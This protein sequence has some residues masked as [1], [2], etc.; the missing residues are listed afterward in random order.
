MVTASPRATAGPEASSE[1]TGWGRGV[2]AIGYGL[3]FLLVVY[4]A[5]AGGGYDPVVYGEVGVICWWV[6]TLGAL[7]GLL[8][9]ARISGAA[10]VALGLLGAFALWTGLGISWSESSERS[11]AELARVA[12]FVGVFAL[13]ISVQGRALALRRTVYAVAAAIG[14]VTLFAL[15]SRLHPELFPEIQAARFLDDVEARLSYPLDYW[16]ALAALIAIGFPLV[17][18]AAMSARNL[19]VQAIAAAALPMMAL[20]AFFTLSRGGAFAIAIAIAAFVLLYPRRLAAAP[21]MVLAAIGAAILIAFASGKD[22]L[23]DGLS[24]STAIS[25]G[26]EVLLLTIVVCAVVGLG[27]FAL[28]HARRRGIGPRLEVSRQATLAAVAIVGAIVLVGA[29]AAGAPSKIS[30]RIDEFTEPIAPDPTAG[31][32]RYESLSGN[33]RYQLWTSAVDANATEPLTGIG[34]GTFEFWWTEDRPLDAYARSAHSL[35]LNSLA[36]VGIVG[37]LLIAAFVL[38]PIGVG[39]RRWFRQPASRELLAGAIGGAITFAVVVGVD[40]IWELAA[41][42]VVFL[43]LAAALLTPRDDSLDDK[44]DAAGA[45]PLSIP[46]R[47]GVA[48]AAIA[49]TIA[50]A[51]PTASLVSIRESQADVRS[52]DLDAALAAAREAGDVQPYA[53]TPYYQEAQVLEAEGD[54]EGAAAAAREATEREPTNWRTW[55]VLARIEAEAGNVNEAIEAYERAQALNPRSD[56]LR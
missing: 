25:Q 49:A 11:V 18:S 17:L 35:Y 10:W 7:V 24:D 31:A 43:L 29:I 23:E 15:F 45:E 51:I 50:I 30:D 53:A 36:E 2:A 32:S 34:P 3:P 38:V 42:P 13:A 46:A 6:V 44:A 40:R 41:L 14:V 12:S 4:L 48:A 47:L 37:M 19:V 8:P 20:T 9:L 33:G 39:V 54:L 52:G 55:L 5:F 28:A 56:F 26:N 22:A 27:H 1:P 16:N 21:T